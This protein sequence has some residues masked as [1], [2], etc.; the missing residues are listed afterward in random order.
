MGVLRP[1]QRLL[2]ALEMLVSLC[3][4]AGGAYLIAYSQSA[5]PTRDLE[6]TWFRS[7]TWPGIALVFFVGVCP[8]AVVAATLYGKAIAD[9]GHVAV[10]AG[11]VAWVL[12]EAA[13]VVLAPALQTA[14]SLVGLV[15]LGLGVGEVRRRR[16]STGSSDHRGT[17][18]APRP[19]ADGRGFRVETG[20]GRSITSIGTIVPGSGT[21]V[22]RDGRERAGSIGGR[23]NAECS[24]RQI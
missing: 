19:P 14:V 10:G 11:L 17:D 20:G 4:V 23:G 12:V 16:R 9:M 2:V 15:I 13:W 3:A 8:A 6:G 22:R 5:L 18:S 24:R 7:W 21:F 1:T